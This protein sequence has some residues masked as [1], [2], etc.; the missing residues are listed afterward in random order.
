[1][2]YRP[3]SLLS[4]MS[5]VLERVVFDQINEYIELFLSDLL[6]G[7]HKNHNIQHCLLKML[8]KWKEALDKGKFV[9]A[10]FMDLS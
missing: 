10:I 5:K 2:N 6:A 9:D 4:H 3:V 8:E 7:F 1:M